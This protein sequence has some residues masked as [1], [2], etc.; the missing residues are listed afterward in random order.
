MFTYATIFIG[1][2][3]IALI[4]LVVYRVF[5]GS[6]RSILSSREPISLNSSSTHSRAG[7]KASAVANA[8]AWPAERVHAKPG[9]MAG[10]QLNTP[11]ENAD[12]H[13]QT[14]ENKVSQQQAHHA[15]SGVS[16]K[17]CSLYDVD[18]TAPPVN[19][20][21]AWPHREEKSESAGTAY[22]VTRKAHPKA[23]NDEESDKPW[24]W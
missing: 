4:A 7:K 20:S 17:H 21:D 12:W 16:D 1:S 18:P 3:F 10:A 19:L 22:K 6:S 14:R 9:S 8:P 15:K 23:T 2:I 13:W 11:S 5:M 24:G